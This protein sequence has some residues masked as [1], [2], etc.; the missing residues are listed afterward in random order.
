MLKMMGCDHHFYGFHIWSRIKPNDGSR[1]AW[2]WSGLQVSASI[3]T[4]TAEAIGIELMP[5]LVNKLLMDVFKKNLLEVLHFSD[6]ESPVDVQGQHVGQTSLHNYGW[7]SNHFPPF[8]Q[9]HHPIKHLAASEWHA[10]LHLGPVS[11]AWSGIA[12]NS[13]L[14]AIC[15]CR[16]KAVGAALKMVAREYLVLDTHTAETALKELP[17]LALPPVSHLV[18]I[19]LT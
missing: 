10:L 9:M 8:L 6:D 18:A 5:Y 19:K 3:K 7:V 14:V 4:S 16:Q 11:T 13:P 15:V 2:T 17:F 1:G 12:V